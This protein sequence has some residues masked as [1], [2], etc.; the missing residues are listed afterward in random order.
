MKKQTNAASK[1]GRPK[2]REV[3][4]VTDKRTPLE[5][6][7][8]WPSAV[9][10]RAQRVRNIAQ[11][12]ADPK[13][14]H[15]EISAIISRVASGFQDQEH[16]PEVFTLKLI[17]LLRLQKS[18]LITAAQAILD[19]TPAA[20]IAG[21]F[22]PPSIESPLIR[23][24]EAERQRERDFVGKLCAVAVEYFTLEQ[25]QEFFSAIVELKKGG[26]GGRRNAQ[27]LRAYDDFIMQHKKE[28]SRQL[29]KRFILKTPTDYGGDWPPAGDTTGWK[30]IWNESGLFGLIDKDGKRKS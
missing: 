25:A 12:E 8:D 11:M 17:Q 24:L 20:T 19:N 30:R 14:N 7:W 21:A 6:V 9:A 15:P 28:P 2:K 18:E 3:P 16:S 4:R 26:T 1:K 22:Y 10:G 27:A 5:M 23:N 13:N 29:L